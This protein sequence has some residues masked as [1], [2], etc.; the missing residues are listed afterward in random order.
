[1]LNIEQKLKLFAEHLNKFN[2]DE[3]YEHIT[4]SEP[5]GPTAITFLNGIKCDSSEL[6]WKSFISEQ[7]LSIMNS[8]VSQN[9][10]YSIKVA[11]EINYSDDEVFSFIPYDAQVS[12]NDHVFS[13]C[14]SLEYSLE[15]SAAA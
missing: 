4:S 2:S 15:M 11:S 10:N 7:S 6:S 1:M 13:T 14:D 12:A 3:L 8:I 9:K 5:V